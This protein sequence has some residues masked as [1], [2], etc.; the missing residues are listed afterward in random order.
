M[1]KCLCVVFLLALNKPIL[2]KLLT[3]RI[4]KTKERGFFMKKLLVLMGVFCG[5]VNWNTF[6]FYSDFIIL[7]A[8]KPFCIEF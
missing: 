6:V 4:V 5:I 1:Q 8:F 7:T 3:R 2:L